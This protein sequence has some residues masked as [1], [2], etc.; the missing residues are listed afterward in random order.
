[1]ALAVLLLA[2]A[3]A[4]IILATSPGGSRPASRA[5]VTKRSPRTH[6]RSTAK[7]A[8]SSSPAAGSTSGQSSGAVP[9]STSGSSA[10]PAQGS[11][12][13]AGTGG[14]NSPTGVVESF[15]HLAAAHQYA[16][17]W[18]LADPSFR[19]QLDGYQSF[20]AGQ[21]GD[22]SITFNTATVTSQSPGGATVYVRTTS[23]RD[24]GTQHCYGPINVVR[25]S[26]GWVI[27]HIDIQCS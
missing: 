21:A 3:V 25:G 5:A 6:H 13:P 16:A 4:A 1:M 2:A 11:N 20:Q 17:A 18:A 14:A 8:G 19:N 23:V 10:A 9:G 12:A 24:N 26:S 15:Y 7:P 27:D 22:R